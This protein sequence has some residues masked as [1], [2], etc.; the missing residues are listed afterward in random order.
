MHIGNSRRSEIVCKCKSAKITRSEITLYTVYRL[1]ANRKLSKNVKCLQNLI[2]FITLLRPSVKIT[3]IIH[4]K[5]SVWVLLFKNDYRVY[6]VI[7]I[8][9]N[10]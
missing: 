10:S 4:L 7:L 1:T 5:I 6:S 3:I 2:N 8:N 9:I